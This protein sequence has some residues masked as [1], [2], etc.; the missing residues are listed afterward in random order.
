MKKLTKYVQE[1]LNL[2]HYVQEITYMPITNSYLLLINHKLVQADRLIIATNASIKYIRLNIPNV[3]KDNLNYIKPIKV[4][5]LYT[6]H[7]KPIELK[8]DRVIQTQSIITNIMVCSDNN[9]ILESTFAVNSSNKNS[10]LLNKNEKEVIH[11]LN[12]LF[13]NITGIKFP[14]IV[15]YQFSSYKYGTHY[16]TKIIK[17]N[18]WNSHN[19]IFAGEFV[20][21]YHGW[22]EGSV[23]SAIDTYKIV[24]K[25]LF[26][27][28]L[29]R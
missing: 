27:D 12:K 11:I 21:P 9:T 5:K 29:K 4:I 20:H 2:N 7:D 24:T 1:K 8:K 22:M 23:M 15:D 25:D 14:K 13:E 26:V 3:I 17:T 19:L 10:I 28:K 16:N 18:F 6:L